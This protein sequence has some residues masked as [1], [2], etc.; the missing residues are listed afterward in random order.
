MTGE[1]GF[2]TAN[3]LLTLREAKRDLRKVRDDTNHAKLKGLVNDLKAPYRHQIISAK[4][5]G[6]LLNVQGTTV[7]CIV[8]AAIQ[9]CDLLCTLYDVTPPNL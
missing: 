1:G 5:K 6:F 3:R 4:H 8:L 9:F 2:F 7:T